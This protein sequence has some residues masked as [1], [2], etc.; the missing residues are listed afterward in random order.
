MVKGR[1][2]DDHQLPRMDPSLF[3]DSQ[4]VEIVSDAN[5][6]F[7]GLETVAVS[8]IDRSGNVSAR[9]S[10]KWGQRPEYNRDPNQAYIPVRGAIRNSSF[11]LPRGVHFT[12][13]CDDDMV[14]ECCRAQDG[15]KAIE[16]PHDNSEIGR[17]CIEK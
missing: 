14:L 16:T 15:D 13:L 6:Q 10:L 3:E 1:V 7:N 12:V 9:S 2:G 4:S 8:F 17:Y 11:F 5:S